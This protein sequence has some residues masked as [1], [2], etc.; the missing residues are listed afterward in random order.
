MNIIDST[1][2]YERWLH[3]MTDVQRSAIARKHDEMRKGPFPLLRATFYRWVEHWQALCPELDSRDQDVFLSVGDLHLENF[4]IWL[5]SRQRL[6]W[7]IND[8]DEACELPFTSDLVRLAASIALAAETTGI[9]APL[10]EICH[11]V[12]GGYR[13]GVEAEGRPILVESGSYPELK[14]FAAAIKSPGKFWRKHLNHKDNPRIAR[15]HLPS[16]LE[17]IFRASLSRKARPKYRKEQKPGGLGSLGRRRFTAV[18]GNGKT[19]DMREAKALV[20]SALYWCQDRPRMLSQTGTLLQRAIRNPDPYLQVHDKWLVRRIAP[21]ALKIDFPTS[22]ADQRLALAPM[23]LRLM[24]FETANIHL[25]SRSPAD[26]VHL[27]DSL[28]RK[29]GSRWLEEAT[30]RMVLAVYKDHRAWLRRYK[31]G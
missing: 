28:D 27:L 9:Q 3:K 19:R 13:E 15:A 1:L 29:L 26:L 30:E 8:F 2:D 4:G 16:R 11:H 23:L 14:Q 7:G 5:D 18:V 6:V 24:G 22:Q 10:R 17:D 12:L 31:A 21:D 25:G 20:P